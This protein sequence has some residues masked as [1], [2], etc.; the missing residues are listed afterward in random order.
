MLSFYI[1]DEASPVFFSGQ[2]L[3][4]ILL[5]VAVLLALIWIFIRRKKRKEPEENK[6]D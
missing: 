1:L 5:P 2:V 4:F 6:N 3:L